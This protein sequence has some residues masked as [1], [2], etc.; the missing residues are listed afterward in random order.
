MIWWLKEKKGQASL[1][2]PAFRQQ[3]SGLVSSIELE[4]QDG[5]LATEKLNEALNQEYLMEIESYDIPHIQR[6]N[7]RVCGEAK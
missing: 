5:T 2:Q 6:V 3:Y 1:Y 7:H 4:T